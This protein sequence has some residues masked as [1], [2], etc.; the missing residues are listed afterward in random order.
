[1][2]DSYDHCEPGHTMT[3]CS[4]IG[5]CVCDDITITNENIVYDAYVCELCGEPPYTKDSM[6]KDL[7]NAHRECPSKTQLIICTCDIQCTV[8]CRWCFQSL[9]S[10]AQNRVTQYAKI[11]E[12]Q[13]GRSMSNQNCYI[14]SKS[15]TQ[16]ILE[17]NKYYHGACYKLMKTLS[18]NR[19]TEAKHLQQ[20]WIEH[21]KLSRE[22]GKYERKFSEEELDVLMNM[23]NL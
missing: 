7:H 19:I 11:N 12:C 4:Q 9:R 3:G 21:D 8:K 20:L 16:W 23:E 2:K 14:C 1:M 5:H 6:V 18:E 15:T 10:S 17:D 22:I 13:Q